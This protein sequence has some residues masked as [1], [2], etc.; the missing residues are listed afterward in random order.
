M[1]LIEAPEQRH[2]VIGAVPPVDPEVEHD[3]IDREARPAGQPR[4]A[5]AGRELRGPDGDRQDD[6]RADQEIDAEQADIPREAPPR[7]RRGP[8]E[9]QQ[10]RMVDRRTQTLVNEKDDQD[11]ADQAP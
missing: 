10:Q 3:Q 7:G 8:A 4:R 11:R 5:Q 9:A 1:D 6:Q 2:L